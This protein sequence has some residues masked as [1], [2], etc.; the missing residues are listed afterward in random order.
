MNGPPYN[1]MA[2]GYANEY[3]PSTYQRAANSGFWGILLDEEWMPSQLFCRLSDSIFF[4]LDAN[5]QASYQNSGF[6]EPDKNMW[7]STY[8]QTVQQEKAV[9]DY[10]VKHAMGTL[11]DAASVPYQV[12]TLNDGSTMPVLDRSAFLHSLVASAKTDPAKFLQKLNTS[13]INFNLIDPATNQPFP[14]P[15]PATAMPMVCD[16]VAQSAF[17][18]WQMSVGAQYRMHVIQKQQKLRAR[19]HLIHTAVHTLTGGLGGGGVFGGNSATY[20]I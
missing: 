13:I 8:L 20:G 14:G 1:N 18:N 4:Y 11:Y 15:I 12:I 19:N 9:T 6:I 3:I 5:A 16:W 10:V 2:P 7:W 17:R